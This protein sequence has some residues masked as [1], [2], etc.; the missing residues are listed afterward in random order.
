M[1]LLG[2]AEFKA[3]VA[4]RNEYTPT[5]AAGQSLKVAAGTYWMMALFNMSTPFGR[6]PR[7]GP[8]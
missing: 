7:G 6:R 2:S 8:L 1:T 3:V 5:A 4:G